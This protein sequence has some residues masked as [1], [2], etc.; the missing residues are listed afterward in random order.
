MKRLYVL[1]EGKTE[2]AI[3]KGLLREHLWQHG[4]ESTFIPV[5]TRRD[6]DG[7]K[8]A[9]GG[10]WSK[11]LPHFNVLKR[12]H[13]GSDVRFSSWFDL[14]G[15][16][17]DFPG[18]VRHEGDKDTVRRAESLE[19]CMADAIDDWRFLPYLQRH[20]VEALVLAS[21][22][23]LEDLL[24]PVDHPSLEALR[25][26]LGTLAPEDV[27][28]GPTTAPSRRLASHIAG[29]RKTLHGPLAV[30]GR[31]LSRVRMACPRFDTWVG[32]LERFD[33]QPG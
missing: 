10:T 25:K 4:I 19:A 24:D 11:W 29:Y 32:Q 12:E 1:V 16:P 21:L 13:R 26:E 31:G 6:A 27:N 15:L 17:R 3:A 2:E 9:G 7:R 22:D 20:E 33:P 8:H 23:A 28:D 5:E 14:Y 30:E 18:L